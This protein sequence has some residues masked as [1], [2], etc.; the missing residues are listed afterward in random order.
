MTWLSKVQSSTWLLRQPFPTLGKVGKCHFPFYAA[1]WRK[2]ALPAL[3]S[4]VFAFFCLVG[5]AGRSHCN[6]DIYCRS[7][8]H[9]LF[10]SQTAST[11][12]E[13]QPPV[14][15]RP[16]VAACL[17]CTDFKTLLKKVGKWKG[18]PT[19]L[20]FLSFTASP[21]QVLEAAKPPLL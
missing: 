3:S 14:C 9:W 11:G 21:L 7:L 16:A 19:S 20:Q 17:Q 8:E 13:Q 4:T 15:K 18:E 6:T 10:L 1:G 5:R 12:W 2:R